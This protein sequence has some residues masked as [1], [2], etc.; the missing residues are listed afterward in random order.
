MLHTTSGY[1]KH[2]KHIIHAVIPIGWSTFSDEERYNEMFFIYLNV[3]N[4][5]E[6]NLGL[7]SIALQMIDANS[8]VEQVKINKINALAF[9]EALKSYL[10]LAFNNGGSGLLKKIFITPAGSRINVVDNCLFELKNYLSIK[11][12]LNLNLLDELDEYR[13]SLLISSRYSNDANTTSRLSASPSTSRQ[14]SVTTS[15]RLNDDSKRNTYKVEIK[16]DSS[17]FKPIVDVNNNMVSNKK[18]LNCKKEVNLKL[19]LN[20]NDRTKCKLSKCEICNI[21]LKIIEISRILYRKYNNIASSL[22]ISHLCINCSI[23]LLV[24]S[25]EMN[26]VCA[27]CYGNYS[28]K[29]NNLNKVCNLHSICEKCIKKLYLSGLQCKFCLL[30]KLNIYLDKINKVNLFDNH[31][32]INCSYDFCDLKSSSSA[33]TPVLSNEIPTIEL[34]CGHVSCFSIR[35]RILESNHNQ[36]TASTSSTGV[37]NT[38]ACTFCIFKKLFEILTNNKNTGETVSLIVER[39]DFNQQ[40][41]DNDENYDV[42]KF[43]NTAVTKPITLTDERSFKP[44]KDK[45]F[46]DDDSIEELNKSEFFMFL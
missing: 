25:L 10:E 22:T 20:E 43:N 38:A 16:V 5:A 6:Q 15:S 17:S 19:I 23:E 32:L 33:F 21:L 18:C 13:K 3:F 2:Y 28:N 40:Y 41:D 12:Y 30:N 1:L 44:I 8:Y 36:A 35:N 9:I 7:K 24:N 14:S 37:A 34:T 39:N 27:C 11:N 42:H 4:Y 31:D 46:L 29:T 26:N 45:I